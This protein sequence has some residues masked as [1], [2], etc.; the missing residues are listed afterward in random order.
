MGV[1]VDHPALVR[2]HADRP[3]ALSS[4]ETPALSAIGE[5]Y[6]SARVHRLHDWRAEQ[7]SA[8]ALG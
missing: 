8:Q 2:A 7:S 6:E 3:P 4:R 5:S 1:H